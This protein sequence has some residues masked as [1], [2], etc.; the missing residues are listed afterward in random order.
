MKFLPLFLIFIGVLQTSFANDAS[1][2]EQAIIRSI[3]EAD[4][5][6]NYIEVSEEGFPLDHYVQLLKLIDSFKFTA[7]PDEKINELF[8]T[9][10]KDRQ[11]RMRYAGGDC[12]KRRAYIQNYLKKMRIVSGKIFIHCPA[13][14][15]RMRLKDRAT[16]HN[17]SFA[18]FHDANIVTNQSS[19]GN[20]FFVMD[21]Q[22]QDNPVS[23]HDYLTEIEASQKIR[24][25]KRRDGTARGYCYWSI[26]TPHL[27]Y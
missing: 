27:S 16:G 15:G 12:S 23:L 14:N 20:D 6:E 3:D 17:Y 8:E 22:F 2:F 4:T 7:L 5:P 9:L 1:D 11:A 24:P 13:N 19:S 18:N 21:L 26:S 25:A 10:K